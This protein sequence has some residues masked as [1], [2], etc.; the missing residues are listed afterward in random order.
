MIDHEIDAHHAALAV[1]WQLI[2]DCNQTSADQG[3]HQ[4]PNGR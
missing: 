3:F 4:A 2:V 1:L